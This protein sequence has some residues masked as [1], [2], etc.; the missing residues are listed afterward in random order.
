MARFGGEKVI[1]RTM[2]I[3][4]QGEQPFKITDGYVSRRHCEITPTSRVGVFHLKDLDSSNGTFVNGI[5]VVECDVTYN[6]TLTLGKNYVVD[7]SSLFPLKKSEESNSL[8]GLSVVF[9]QHLRQVYNSHAEEKQKIAS[10]QRWGMVW[11]LFVP[12][13]FTQALAPLLHLEGGVG[14]AIGLVVG[15]LVTVVI[16]K[17]T[18]S[19]SK[20]IEEL[21]NQFKQ[22]Y[23]CG[24]CNRFLG[25]FPP[26][27]I[28]NN[29]KCT[30][31][32]CKKPII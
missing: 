22:K 3:G 29:L 8:S 2:V 25:D 12:Q 32:N 20:Q 23:V 26:E 14:P 17:A 19:S 7:L 4:K 28:E 6:D 15:L 18:D 31:L 1:D 5:R 27:Y 9:P 16:T 21:N 24:R 13:I 11:R 30:C 10:S